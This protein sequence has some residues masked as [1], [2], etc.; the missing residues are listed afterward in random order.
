KKIDKNISDE[1]FSSNNI[2]RVYLSGR[3][4]IKI[5]KFI[6][7]LFNKEFSDKEIEDFVNLF[8]S[9]MKKK[10]EVFEIVEGD[11]IEYWYNCDNY[12][13]KKGNLGNSC[14][15]YGDDIFEI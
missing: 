14:M 9:E 4:E 8:K 1:I 2:N 6:N 15:R 5:G 3:S 11:D 7:K 13:N 10:T 12:L